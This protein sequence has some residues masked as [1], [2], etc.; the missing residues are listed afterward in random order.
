MTFFGLFNYTRCH[1]NNFKKKTLLLPKKLL[2]RDPT[3]N[4]FNVYT[5]ATFKLIKCKRYERTWNIYIIV[6]NFETLLP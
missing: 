6:K 5:G 4:L 2:S 1:T 3:V